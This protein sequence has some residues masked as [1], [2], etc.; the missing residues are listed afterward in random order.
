MTDSQSN[1]KMKACPNGEHLKPES[2][3]IGAKSQIVK[4]CKDCRDSTKKG[5]AERKK[6]KPPE[7]KKLCNGNHY[8][9]IDLFKEL[10][11]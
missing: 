9:E 6:K 10:N 8:A 4:R 11:N 1:I 5:K 2:D 7:G 3:F